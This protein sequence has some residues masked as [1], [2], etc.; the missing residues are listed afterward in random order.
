MSCVLRVRGI[1]FLVDAFLPRSSLRPVAVF[2]KGQPR[3]PT[4][5]PEGPKLD[6]SG[7]HVVVSEADFPM[8]QAQIADAA[9]FLER[10]RVEL[11]H[12]M[13]FPG[14]DRVSL[15]FGIEEREVAAQSERFPPKLLSLLGELGI[16]LEFTLYPA[17]E[18]ETS[19]C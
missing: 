12:L 3:Y 4:V 15:D 6:A 1:D 19:K 7:F 10:N 8:L 18:T 2:R 13:A 11:L 17:H 14:I 16:W 5:K 9:E